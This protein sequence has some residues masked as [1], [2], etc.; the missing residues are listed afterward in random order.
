MMAKPVDATD[1][2]VT[3]SGHY[4]SMSDARHISN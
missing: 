1:G 2:A 3:L 4:F